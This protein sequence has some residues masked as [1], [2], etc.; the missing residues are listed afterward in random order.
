MV[1]HHSSI[2]DT[3]GQFVSWSRISRWSSSRSATRR[4]Y[5][6]TLD[7]LVSTE[8][9]NFR[10]SRSMPTRPHPPEHYSSVSPRIIPARN[11]VPSKRT[12]SNICVNSALSGRKQWERAKF[13]KSKFC[14]SFVAEKDQTIFSHETGHWTSL[15]TL[16]KH[17]CWQPT[18][19]RR[20]AIAIFD[21]RNK[22]PLLCLHRSVRKSHRS[23]LIGALWLDN[24]LYLRITALFCKMLYRYEW[25][26]K[27]DDRTIC[28]I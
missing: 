14:S 11:S 13:R 12:L 20:G 15:W 22:L 1:L 6:R 26:T 8:F 21:C 2:R 4:R 7:F 28:L 3:S 17:L 27:K 10:Q 25:S 9:C 23:I 5:Q 24:D 16:G 18:K 19:Y